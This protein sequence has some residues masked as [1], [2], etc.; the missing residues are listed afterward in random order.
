MQAGH[1]ELATVFERLPQAVGPTLPHLL[2]P[3]SEG[4]EEDEDHDGPDA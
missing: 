1:K 3:D 4:D 2:A